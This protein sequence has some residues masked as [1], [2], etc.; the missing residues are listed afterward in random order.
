MTQAQFATWLGCSKA[1][2]V[3][4]EI[5]RNTIPEWVSARVNADG[6]VLNPKFSLSEF[7]KIQEAANAE[8]ITVEDWIGN[9]IKNAIK[10]L[11]FLCLV[12]KVIQGPTDWSAGAIATSVGTGVSWFATGAGYLLGFAWQ[13]GGAILAAL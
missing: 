2:V 11:A 7:K 13:A 12:A 3:A 1:A 9:I 5:A 8:G 10:L 6:P 4:W